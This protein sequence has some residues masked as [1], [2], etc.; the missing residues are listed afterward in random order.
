MQANAWWEAKK[1]EIDA[2]ER[3]EKETPE[4]MAEAKVAVARRPEQ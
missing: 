1:A 4:A 3:A 2:A